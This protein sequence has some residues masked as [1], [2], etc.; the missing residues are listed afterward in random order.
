MAACLVALALV[1]CSSSPRSVTG[2]GAADDVPQTDVLARPWPERA[3]PT[4]PWSA[5]MDGVGPRM[6][7]NMAATVVGGL[8]GTTLGLGDREPGQPTA[9]PML[10]LGGGEQ[11]YPDGDFRLEADGDVS[12]P[13]VTDDAS[14]EADGVRSIDAAGSA[15]VARVAFSDLL[16]G[17]TGPVVARGSFYALAGGHVEELVLPPG[18]TFSGP[19]HTIPAIT[20]EPTTIPAPGDCDRQLPDGTPIIATVP[21]SRGMVVRA[22]G[23]G[24][25]AVAGQARATALDR[26]WDGL[27]VA[28]EGLGIEAGATFDGRQWSVTA[29]AADARQV[30][31]DVWPVIDTV[32]QARSFSTG[33]GIFD[34]NPL[35]RVEW[36]NVGFATAQILEAEGVGPGAPSVGFDLNKTLSH[37]AGLGARR[38]DTVINLDGGADIDSNLPPGGETD[39]ELSYAAGQPATLVLRGN[40]PEVTVELAVPGT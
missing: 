5:S 31:V 7:L 17:A 37:D 38:G 23:A 11:W 40:F 6:T 22:A 20:F 29:Q 21:A 36:V 14:L 24:E 15:I 19:C 16:D 12:V 26:S 34:R 2:A 3:T 28:V 10:R 25:V 1:A 9:G 30:W 8:R 4:G 27:V 39:R 13:G 18:T 33:P 35:L 32:L